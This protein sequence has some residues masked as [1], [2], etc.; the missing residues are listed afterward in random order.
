M[1]D[2][3]KHNGVFLI[4]IFIFILFF[5]AGCKG[6]TIKGHQVYYVSWNEG[7][8]R[9]QRLIKH[10]DAASFKI[11]DNKDY[12]KD[13]Y[14]VY[15]EGAIVPGADPF[16]FEMIDE[17]YGKDKY[18]GY[19]CGD[20]ILSASSKGFSVINSYYAKDEHDVY[21]TTYPLHVCNPNAF[22]YLGPDDN[23]DVNSWSTDGCNYFYM[24]YKIPSQDY[25]HTHYFL[26]SGGIAAD[27]DH[28]YFLDHQINFDIDGKKVMDTVDVKSFKVT[29][30]LECRDKWGCINP[31]HGREVCP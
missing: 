13:K 25:K 24:Q 29:N 6:Y 20:S 14:H 9:N 10:A 30:F 5:L 2:H 12:G 18:R 4:S 28:V 19:F 8:G 3:H 16:S 26:K 27:A 1:I 31:Y 11:L 15:K 7:S 21:Y 22:K 23:L 17:W